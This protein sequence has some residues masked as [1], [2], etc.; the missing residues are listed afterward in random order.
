MQKFDSILLRAVLTSPLS[1]SD[2]FLPQTKKS[3]TKGNKLQVSMV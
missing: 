3:K 1:I 2:Y